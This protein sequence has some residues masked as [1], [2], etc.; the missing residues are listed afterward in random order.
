MVQVMIYDLIFGAR[1][2]SGG[3]QV[4]RLLVDFQPALQTELQKMMDISHVVEPG[5][6]VPTSLQ[7]ERMSFTYI[8]TI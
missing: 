6:L 2:I 4:K 5:R 7:S 3:G 1:K 8:V